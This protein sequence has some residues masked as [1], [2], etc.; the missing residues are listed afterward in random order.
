MYAK[1]KGSWH[2]VLHRFE[3]VA[4]F[5]VNTITACTWI[6]YN[7]TC[8]M[9]PSVLFRVRFIHTIIQC[10]HTWWYY[11]RQLKALVVANDDIGCSIYQAMQFHLYIYWGLHKA[12]L[13]N[14]RHMGAAVMGH[15]ENTCLLETPNLVFTFLA[16]LCTWIRPRGNT[17]SYRSWLGLSR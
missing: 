12:N 6:F 5:K 2:G 17:F 14:S 1:E 10:K 16:E 3:I 4:T 9:L 11:S 8:D 15:R 13:R 7:S